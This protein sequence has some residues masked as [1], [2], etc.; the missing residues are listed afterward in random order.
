MKDVMIE[1][2]KG[3]KEPYDEAKVRRSI[4]KTGADDRVTDAVLAYVRKHLKN[5][6]KTSEIYNMVREQLRASTPWAAARYN[7]RDAIIR[8]GP[9]GFN[10]EKYV[11]AVLSAYGY[12]TETPESYKGACITHEVDVTAEKDG[13]IAFIEAKFRRDFNGVVSIKDTLATWAR[14]LDLVD[15]S[16]IDLC[17]HFDEVW[18]V[19]NARFTDQSL[20]F[21]HCKN[22]KLVGWNHP[23]ERTF[24]DMVDMDSLYPITV[25]DGLAEKELAA[26]ARANFILC[27]D[28]CHMEP[29]ELENVTGISV[30]RL[31]SIVKMC[32]HVVFGDKSIKN[33]PPEVDTE[34]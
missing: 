32:D 5:G 6:I 20:E 30:D 3:I 21:G 15:G 23:T 27:R 10:F 29:Q 19:T 24:A 12:K 14:F 28:V 4:K 1:K 11:A 26:F 31:A 25:I 7:L 34:G 18:I 17:P 16:R 13:R 33:R 8:L 22:M 9:A 2:A